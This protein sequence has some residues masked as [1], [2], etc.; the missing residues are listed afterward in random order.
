VIEYDSVCGLGETDGWCV[1]LKSLHGSKKAARSFPQP[2]FVL[3]E[4]F[5]FADKGMSA[6]VIAAGVAALALVALLL[7]MR[8]PKV[9]SELAR[10]CSAVRRQQRHLC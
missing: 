3:L 4:L 1:A 9:R 10:A 2:A 7:W 8:L 6:A 5:C